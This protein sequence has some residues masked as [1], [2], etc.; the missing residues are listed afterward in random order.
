MRAKP[1]SPRKHRIAVLA[2]FGASLFSTTPGRADVT[3][4]ISLGY[5]ARGSCPPEDEFLALVRSQTTRWTRASEGTTAGRTMRVVVVESASETR[6]RLVVSNTKGIVSEREIVGPSCAAV[7]RAMAIMVAVAIDPRAGFADLPADERLTTEPRERMTREP[8][9]EHPTPPADHPAPPADRPARPAGEQSAPARRDLL[10]ISL[11][12]RAESTSA[13]VRGSLLGIGASMKFEPAEGAGP[14]WFRAWKPNVA[15]GIRQSF[16]RELAIRGG[17][18]EFLWTAAHARACPFSWTIPRTF[19][20]SPCAEINVGRLSAVAEGFSEARA[21]TTLWY[22]LGG[23]M[24]ATVRIAGRMFLSSTFLVTAPG[25]RQ[26]FVL[27]SGAII[28]DAPAVGVL[29]GLGLG[30]AM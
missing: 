2:A 11:D 28:S 17:S 23:S 9:A 22:D 3:E 19:T 18:A 14:S 15:I 10:R 8:S 7:T 13:V 21:V 27:A 5:E 25:V 4:A 24:W 26:P 30:M 12:V 29:G 1:I 20:I 6:G 16:P